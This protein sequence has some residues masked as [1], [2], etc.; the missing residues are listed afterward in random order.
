ML[1]ELGIA[2]IPQERSVFPDMTVQENLELG[3]WAIRNDRSHAERAIQ[4]VYEDFPVLEEKRDERAESMSG[5]Q[6]RMLELGRSLL[7]DPEVVLV[8]EPTV[9]LAPVIA[10]DIYDAIVDLRTSGITVLLV[11]QNVR[12]A[13]EVADEIF[14]L[15]RG[16]VAISGNREDVSAEIESIISGWISPESVS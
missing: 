15:E 14:I 6:Q 9:G 3:T 2:Y 1:T 4:G 5:G 13:V 8:D 11:D 12:P 7:V 10:S 16:E